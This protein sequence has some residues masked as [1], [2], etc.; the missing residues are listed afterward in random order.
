MLKYILEH[1]GVYFARRHA[2]ERSIGRVCKDVLDYLGA[3]YVK[4]LI[5]LADLQR[6]LRISVGTAARRPDAS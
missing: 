5:Q 3:Q 6:S 1:D 4:R 2:H